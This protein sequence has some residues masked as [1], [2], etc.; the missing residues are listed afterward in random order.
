MLSSGN[1]TSGRGNSTN[2][3]GQVVVA[4]MLV[5]CPLR[6]LV[7]SNQV[8]RLNLPRQRDYDHREQITVDQFQPLCP[9]SVHSNWARFSPNWC[10]ERQIMTTICHF[11]SDLC[12]LKLIHIFINTQHIFMFNVSI[13][14]DF[15]GVIWY[16]LQKFMFESL[17]KLFNDRTSAD[18]MMYLANF[19]TTQPG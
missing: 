3:P 10:W 14:I 9:T 12:N 18:A 8:P 15:Q 17:T 7:N 2:S 6:I 16:S 13:L 19:N 1:L 5:F 11:F 4:R